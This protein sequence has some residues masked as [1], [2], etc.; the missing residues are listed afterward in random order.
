MTE[1][2]DRNK[3]AVNW[4]MGGSAENDGKT[5]P[6]TVTEQASDERRG[7]WGR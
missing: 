2:N 1:D 6:P 3:A 7:G 5:T 4:L